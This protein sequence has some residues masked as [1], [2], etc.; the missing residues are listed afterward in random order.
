MFVYSIV[1]AINAKAWEEL[2]DPDDFVSHRI[3]IMESLKD[4]PDKF[5][6]YAYKLWVATYVS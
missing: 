3:K 2:E 4:S 1:I 6:C 5:L